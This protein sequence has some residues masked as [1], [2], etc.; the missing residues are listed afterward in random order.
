MNPKQVRLDSIQQGFDL[1]FSYIPLNGKIPIQKDWQKK[2]RASLEESVSFAS[3]NVGI[4]TGKSSGG[5]IVVDIDNGADVSNMD[6]PDTITVETG[7]GGRHLYY[8]TDKQIKNSVSK[9]GKNIDIRGDGGQVVAVG[10]VHPKTRQIY[11]YLVSP[12]ERDMADLP[13]WIVKRLNSTR[14][15]T[16]KI[17]TEYSKYVQSAIRNECDAVKS[18]SEGTRNNALNISAFSLAQ[19]VPLNLL[20]EDEIEVILLQATDL[21][22]AE[23]I[24][25]IRSGIQAGREKP[26]VIPDNFKDIAPETEKV[27]ADNSV[28]VPLTHETPE[29]RKEVST[30]VFTNDVINKLPEGAIYKRADT[31][32]ELSGNAGSR[33]FIPVNADRMRIISDKNVRMAKYKSGTD[34]ET[35]EVYYFSQFVP[36]SRDYGKIILEASVHD[37]RIKTVDM[38]T[39]YPVY[40]RT[41]ELAKAG[42]DHGVFYDEPEELK[43]VKPNFEMDPIF[44][45]LVDFPFHEKEDKINFISLLLTPLIR[46]AIVGNVPMFLIKAS[47]ARTGKTKLAEEVVGGIYQGSHTPAMQLTGSEDERDKRILSLLLGGDTIVHIDNV[48]A[49]LDSPSLA[50][51]VTA[52]K[53][54]GRLLGSS[55]VVDINVNFTIIATGNNPQATNEIVKRCIPIT[56]QPE[57]DHP[58]LRSDFAHPDIFQYILDRRHE[59]YCSM[60]GMVE[61]WKKEGRKAGK[62]RMG[63]FEAWVSVMGGI[64]EAN[65][66]KKWLSNW[67]AFVHA[68]DPEGEDLRDFAKI[69]FNEYHDMAVQSNQ[70]Y[71][72]A[73]D[74]DLFSMVMSRSSSDRGRQTIFGMKILAKCVN[75]PIGK[76]I[77][78]KGS[79]NK[80]WLELRKG[81]Q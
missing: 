12:E 26:R 15:K 67:K 56:L 51:L 27:I 4:R 30:H 5:L 71:D 40:N 33:R 58:E 65:G 46:P 70:L 22:E 31:I 74:N 25:T 8:W 80:Y 35:G 6:L 19:F 9:L 55:K 24:R 45:I 42:L 76:Y 61:R 16:S 59:I 53:Y 81:E 39:N 17:N 62:A 47:L 37:R 73:E 41:W 57:T 11:K 77:V 72:I 69:W 1:G 32:V 78:R 43:D 13:D 49:Y 36:A 44:D 3:G 75:A 34:R 63:G 66:F 21:P 23:A 14:K 10:T 64:L 79:R 29:G 50:S 20:T 68:S 7:S 18:A 38:L 48:S 60:I 52:K 28:L 54:R 2:K